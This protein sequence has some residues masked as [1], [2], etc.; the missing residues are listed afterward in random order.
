DDMSAIVEFSANRWTASATPDQS[1]HGALKAEVVEERVWPGVC[2][3]RAADGRCRDFIRQFLLSPTWTVGAS[4]A[5]ATAAT[6][7]VDAGRERRAFSNI[8]RALGRWTG[9]NSGEGNDTARSG[10]SGHVHFDSNRVAWCL[11]GS[12]TGWVTPHDGDHCAVGPGRIA[13]G[14]PVDF[15]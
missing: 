1:L 13:G 7:H 9:R 4:A 11:P 15:R 14:K 8:R 12:R 5:A 2:V 6:R 10:W 3:M